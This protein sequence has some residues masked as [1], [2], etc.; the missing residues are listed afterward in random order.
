MP[1][2]YRLFLIVMAIS[3][4]IDQI[5][6][7]WARLAL[8]KYGDHGYA[9]IEGFF[10]LR[11]SFNRGIAWGMFSSLTG[12]RI[13]LSLVNLLACVAIF[14]YVRKANDSQKWFASALGL[15]GGGAFGN[16]IDRILVGQV[17]D[18]IL[19]QVRSYRWPVFNIADAS[20]VIG[21][22]IL[23]L[24]IGHEQRRKNRQPE[25]TPTDKPTDKPTE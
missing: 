19:W 11:L 7:Y 25:G 2:R 5:S 15:V 17:T 20:L 1:R 23:F 8:E 9:L 12:G 6:K 4:A 21:V 18:F 22:A 14:L 3:V 13:V 24:D 16:A 10:H